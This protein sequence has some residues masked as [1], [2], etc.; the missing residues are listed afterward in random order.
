M[1][2]PDRGHLRRAR[3][4]VVGE[5]RSERLCRLVVG[6]LLVERGP[7]PLRGAAEDLAV[8]DHRIDEDPAILDD[9]VVEDLDPARL[10]VHLDDAGVTGVGERPRIA[11]RPVALGDLESPG[12]RVVRQVLGLP[13][14]QAPDVCEAH[15]SAPRSPCPAVA[16]HE[17]LGLDL[18][19]VGGEVLHPLAERLA[20]GRHRPARHHHAAR[21]PGAGRVGR[22]RGVAVHHLHLPVVD[23]EDLVR[24]LG[25]GRFEPLS[26]RVDPDP[27]LEPAVRGEAG[28]GLLVAGH[29]GHSP[30]GVDRGAVRSLLA[31]DRVARP[32]VAPG[33]ARV[34]VPSRAAPPAVG[35]AVV[36][37]IAIRHPAIPA[38]FR[39]VSL[40]AALGRGSVREG[41]R[42]PAQ[43]LR[44]VPAVE[45]LGG[46]VVERHLVG[47]NQVRE[48]ELDR[49]HAKLAGHRV[50]EHLEGEAHPGPRHPAVGQDGGLV[51]RHRPGAAVVSLE[52]VGSGE[53]APHLGGLEPGR[54]RIGGV[55]AGVDVGLALDPEE[56]PVR[57]RVAGDDVV[58]LAAVRVAGELLATVF[59]PAYRVTAAHCEPAEKHL[60]GEQDPLVAEAA[61]HVR[62]DHPDA[63]LRDPEAL[64]EAVPHDVRHLAG[65]PDD[66]H[67]LAPVPPRDHRPPL[68]G[69]HALP[70]GAEGAGDGDRRLVAQRTEV[71]AGHRFEEHVVPPFVVEEGGGGVAGLAR[72]VHGRQLLEVEPH[73]L[74]EVL[75]RR[76]VVGH[77]GGED[78]PHVPHPLRGEDRLARALEPGEGGG[79]ED[80]RDALEVHGGEHLA[81]ATGRFRHAAHPGVGKRAPHERHVA[82]AGEP[83]VGDELPLA[84]EMTRVLDPFDARADAAPRLRHDSAIAPPVVVVRWE[85]YAGRRPNQRRRGRPARRPGRAAKGGSR[86]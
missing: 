27:E 74:R 9:H 24:D 80:G 23:A 76:P 59:D 22:V 77:A 60:L 30:C 65:G 33:A 39:A 35:I 34:R 78:L 13:V 57:R 43:T 19:Q 8:H 79:G 54:E 47:P 84:V 52:D 16:E 11:H 49:V 26:V 68:E 81:L 42:R 41:R 63:A 32:D 5:G 51:G 45:V 85:Y 12:V 3:Q 58:V 20:G 10:H 15:P 72:I 37:A 29:H 56:A 44:V 64:R 71:R 53:N 40:R 70:G 25:E 62:R 82:G 73:R 17:R 48:A 83:E 46:D 31:E 1:L 36:T 4:P 38:S 69:R 14:P 6:H 75:G 21:A 50:E 2:D 67:V 86:W 55:G 18:E 7:D 28:G 61:P 66:Q